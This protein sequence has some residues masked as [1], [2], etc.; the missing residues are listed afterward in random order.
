MFFIFNNVQYSI[1]FRLCLLSLDTWSERQEELELVFYRFQPIIQWQLC[2]TSMT[3]AAFMLEKMAM[4]QHCGS[5]T[6]SLY[7]DVH[8]ATTKLRGLPGLQ[9]VALGPSS[10]YTAILTSGLASNIWHPN[11]LF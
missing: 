7:G 2:G 1:F 6:P 10:Y 9:G 4:W 11:S 3:V 5:I 8:P